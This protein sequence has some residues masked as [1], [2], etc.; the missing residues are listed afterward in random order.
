MSAPVAELLAQA[1]ALHRQGALAQ[2][3]ALYQEALRADGGNAEAHYYLAMI[4]CQHGRFEEGAALV[5]RSLAANPLHAPA[6]VLLGRALNATARHGEAIAAFDRALALDPTLAA[7]HSHRGNA[8]SDLGRNAEAVESYDRALALAP[9]SAADWFDR[10]MALAAIGRHG[11]A[12]TSFDQAIARQPDFAQAHLGRAKALGDLGRYEEALAGTQRALELL[13]DL[14]EAWLGRGNILGALKRDDEAAAAYDKAIALNA[15]LADAWLGRAALHLEAAQFDAALAAYDRTLILQPGA[16]KAWL[17]RGNA[18]SRL[19]RTD[20]AAAAYDKAIALKPD[21]AGAWLGRGNV[22]AALKHNAEAA[23]AYDEALRLDGELAEA[24]LGRGNVFLDVQRYRDALAAY[25][26][27]IFLK[28]D[29][30][31]A[32]LGRGNML[33]EFGDHGAAVAAYDKAVSLKPDLPYAPG[34]RLHAR[35]FICDWPAFADESTAVLAALRSGKPAIAPFAALAIASSAADQLQCARRYSGDQPAFAPLWRGETYDHARLRIAYLSAD[36]HEHATAYLMAGLFEQHDRRNFE[37]T[38]VS[39]GPNDGSAM[40]RRLEKAFDDFVDVK[41]MSDQDIAALMRRREIDI[42]VDLKG[43]TGAN[44]LHILAR[45]AAPVQVSYLGYPGTMAAGFIDYILADEV[46]IPARQSAFYSEQVV[47]LPGSYQVNDNSRVLAAAVTP[48][49]D[50]GLPRDGF[51]FCCFNNSYKITPDMFDIWMR[52]L[53]KV[54]GSV[55]WLLEANVVATRNLRGEAAKRGVDPERLVFA[56]RAS[57]ADHLA[58]QRHADLFIDTLP[59]NAHTTASDA[60]WAGLPVLT[61]L[62]ETFAGR[63]AASLLQ[64]AGLDELITTSLSDYEALA[65]KLAR[66]PALLA[67]IK[68]RLAQNRDSCPL[69]DTARATRGIEA[70]YTLMWQRY[71]NGERPQ[72]GGPPIRVD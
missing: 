15:G 68:T 38:A 10:G 72:P 44:R 62:G 9:D 32:W 48:R 55:L 39:W 71:Q 40:R 46:T 67:S 56:P 70:A 41:A 2:A 33:T 58:R 20:A 60:L 19:N 64:A 47:W 53:Q 50:C 59:Y 6:H 16:A 37:I 51:V 24:W 3:Q 29:L 4:A 26:K 52:L 54:A 42:A 61:C 27:A 17:G 43:F 35:Q 30:A 57:A 34:A 31:E 21:L 12:V 36:F 14:A 69:F 66:D 8:L 18:L 45:R 23:A 5:G 1:L 22:C 7:A 11:D 25:D 63:V 13:P 28:P 49:Q 65:L